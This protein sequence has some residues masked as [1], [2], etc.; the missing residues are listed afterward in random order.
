MAKVGLDFRNLNTLWAS[1]LVE[2]LHRL[3]LTTAVL[4]PGSRSAPLTV[5]FARHS[6]IEAIPVLD[7]RSAAFF[8]LGLARQSGLPVAL[9]C[10][11]GTAAANFYPALIE[12]RESRV[13]L[14]V[15]TADRPPELRHCHAGQAIDQVK[16]YGHYPQW[17]TE[18]AVPDL[19]NLAYLRQTVVHAWQRSL[20]PTPGPVHLNIPLRDPLAPVLQPEIAELEAHFPTDFLTAIQPPAQLLTTVTAGLDPLIKQWQSC[21]RGVIIAGPVQPHD[22]QGY[23]R[24]IASLCQVLGWPVLADG[25]SPLRNYAELNPFLI[26]TYDLLLRHPDQAERLRS[27]IVV[28]L[29]ELPT[30]KPLRTWLQHTQPRTWLIAPGLDNFDPLHGQTTTL[31]LNVETLARALEQVEF[32][33]RSL[34][35]C[36]QWLSLDHR[37]KASIQAAFEEIDWLFEPKVAW[38]LSQILPPATPLF[39]ASSMPVRDL[40][41]YWQPG[42]SRIQP[43][44]NRGANGIDGTLSTA[45]GIA[46]RQNP[47]VLLTGDLSLLHDVNGFLISNFLQNN[48]WQ[49]HLTIV[50]I[51]NNGGGIFANLPIANFEPPF[52]TFFA[53][54]QNINFAQLCLTYGVDYELIQSWPQLK[55][56]LNPLPET[57][58]RLLE[59]QSDRRRDAQQRRFYAEQLVHSAAT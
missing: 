56:R 32:E 52:E 35:Y 40:E 5:A 51:N 24:G 53:T 19:E 2:T 55:A 58:I 44:F 23:C 14:L 41:T 21:D 34:D 4:C 30:S 59:I 20:L 36:K 12:A 17:Q 26:S 49:G 50:L 39:I 7:E 31:D 54:P 25:L 22:S 16:L 3:G 42:T 57:G 47:A 48:H 27:Q 46:Y 13:A 1:I 15:L 37:I 38:M 33:P 18:L 6:E 11:S 43:Y 10:T 9:V 28:Q 29:G 45:L 8:A